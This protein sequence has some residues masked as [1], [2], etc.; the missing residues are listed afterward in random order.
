MKKILKLTLGEEVFLNV[1]LDVNDGGSAPPVCNYTYSDWGPCQTNNTQIRT[2]VSV[3]PPGC[4]GIPDLVRSCNYVDPNPVGPPDGSKTRPFKLDQVLANGNGMA[5]H[6][7]PSFT[8]AANS[9]VYF[10]VDPAACPNPML[11]IMNVMGY[12]NPI[13]KFSFL[14]INKSTGQEVQGEIP[15]WQNSSLG[16]NVWNQGRFA[17]NK[18]VFGVENP[19]PAWTIDIWWSW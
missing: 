17:I 14:I 2:V 8:L 6:T 13:L 3:G 18:W 9:K 19:G 12:N 7:Y 16:F 11:F 15:L 4:V 1:E 10:E 5:L